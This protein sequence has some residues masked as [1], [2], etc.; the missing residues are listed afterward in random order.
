[1]FSTTRF[2][3]SNIYHQ[4]RCPNS[5]QSFPIHWSI[6]LCFIDWS[7]VS[8]IDWLCFSCLWICEAFLLLDP[9]YCAKVPF[10]SIERF[11]NQNSIFY[12]YG[13]FSIEKKCIFVL[14]Y[15]LGCSKFKSN[16]SAGDT[17]ALALFETVLSLICCFL[18]RTL[19]LNCTLTLL[20]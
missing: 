6:N 20:G 3:V 2:I 7:A 10:T 13:F 15:F 1:M 12:Y 11:L 9:P 16:C 14:F 4:L 18:H 19:G 5:S 17:S 8:K